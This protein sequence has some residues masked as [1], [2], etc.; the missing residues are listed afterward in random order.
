MSI[1]MPGDSAR[2][3][4]LPDRPIFVGYPT[5]WQAN[6]LSYGQPKLP[7][8]TTQARAIATAVFRA[9]AV[10]NEMFWSPL[11]FQILNW[12]VL[13]DRSDIAEWLT[14]DLAECAV[15]KHFRQSITGQMLPAH[16][17]NGA[18][19]LLLEREVQS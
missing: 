5:E 11:E 1:A 16:V 6:I 18:A 10:W 12:A 15:N 14:I 13:F 2:N 4:A 17:I 9:A 3:N 7:V 19:V 8:A